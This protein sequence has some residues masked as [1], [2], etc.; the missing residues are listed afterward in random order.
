M[1]GVDAVVPAGLPF[2]ASRGQEGPGTTGI[3]VVVVG[4][5]LAG[6][7]AARRL[8]RAGVD[9]L[10]V[11][12]RDRLGG[13]ILT[14]DRSGVPDEDGFDLGPSWF[15]PQAQ[16]GLAAL[17]TELGLS[18]FTQNGEGDLVFEQVPRVPPQR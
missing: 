13:R 5:G 12:A 9:F 1:A 3:D 14:V 8:C 10:L 16:P 15:W 6:L 7:Y 2:P 18:T 17:V 4:G 11:E